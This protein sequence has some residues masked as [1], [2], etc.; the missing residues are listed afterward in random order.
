METSDLPP[1]SN[2]LAWDRYE[3]FLADPRFTFAPAPPDLDG[4]WKALALRKTP[5]P[6]LWMDAYLTAFAVRSGFQLVSADKT[7]S[8]FKGLDLH[9]IAAT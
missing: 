2:L 5:S 7:F 4:T 8:Q 1:A 6:K 9:L 3:G